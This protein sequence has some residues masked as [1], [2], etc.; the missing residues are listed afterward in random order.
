MQVQYILQMYELQQ[1]KG[2]VVFYL[3]HNDWNEM[4]VHDVSQ[5]LQY[6]SKP[7]IF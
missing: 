1:N 6:Y 5:W 4:P 7:R 3:S 2:N